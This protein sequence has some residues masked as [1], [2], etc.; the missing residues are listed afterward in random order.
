MR[1]FVKICGLT[2]PEEVA[3]AAE[4]GADGVGLVFH[5][6]SRRAVTVER[7]RRLA[8]EAPPGVIRVGVVAGPSLEELL[9]LVDGVPLDA[10]QWHGPYREAVM[11]ELRRL[12]PRVKM[13]VAA[14]LSGG[15]DGYRDALRLAG[16][17]DYLLLDTLVGRGGTGVPWDW[18]LA[19]G[20]AL[21]LPVIVAGG[22]TPE[23]VGTALERVRPAGVDV[24]SGVESAGVKE[25]G[26]MHRFVQAV[27]QWEQR[28][29]G[30]VRDGSVPVAR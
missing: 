15:K 17:A 29:R 2:R 24:S 13:V 21:P 1:V 8:A 5:P 26:K 12:R 7:A 18:D 3:W 19:T 6:A 10:V 28:F 14:A 20:L 25:R 27:R 11:E 30:G 23:N 9:T 16:L 22:L 4:A